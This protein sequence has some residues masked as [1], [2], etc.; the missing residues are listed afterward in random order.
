MGMPRMLW[1]HRALVAELTRREFSGRYQGSFGGVLWSFVQ[2]L[3]LL[4]VYTIAFGAILKAHWGFSGGTGDYALMIFAGLVVY[5]AFSECLMKAPG[6]VTGN[7]NFV[8]KVVFPLELLPWVMAFTVMLHAAMAVAVWVLG[9]ALL[10]GVPH[11]TA[12]LAP[13]VFACF[14]PILLGIGWLL[15]AV[16]V[17]VRDLG[18]LSALASHALLFLTPIFYGVEAAPPVLRPLLMANPLT[19]V[20]EELRLVLF[21]GQVPGWR[22]LAVYFGLS[23]LFAW[24]SLW[25]FRRMRRGFADMV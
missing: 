8:K 18:Q 16:G 23:C 1:R 15:S 6:L 7:P 9:Y 20:V 13:V 14:F 3:F 5:N 4:A 17:A 22:G 19:F 25:V 2:P 24:A 11:A 12:V 10:R 21:F